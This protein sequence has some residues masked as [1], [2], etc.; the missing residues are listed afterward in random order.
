MQDAADHAHAPATAAAPA[1]PPAATRS[2]P[3]YWGTGRRKSA[4]ARVRMIPGDGKITI[5][6]RTVEQ[7]FTTPQGREAV[8]APLIATTT[9]KRFNIFVSVAGGGHNGQAGAVRLGVARALMLADAAVE[10]ALRDKGYLT[11]DSREVERKKY[12]RRKA[13]R[14][15]QFSKR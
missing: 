15:F 2:G 5:N 9:E 7:Y 12:G 14:R 6:D 11:R 4:V 8:Y 10:P 3:P 1:T 13:R